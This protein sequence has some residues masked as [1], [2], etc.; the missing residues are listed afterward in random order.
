[1]TPENQTIAKHQVMTECAQ[2][3]RLGSLYIG[4]LIN[5]CSRTTWVKN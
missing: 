4:H 2:T 3:L 1:M 5:R